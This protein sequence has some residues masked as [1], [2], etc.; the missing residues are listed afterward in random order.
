MGTWGMV[1][2][3]L[4]GINFVLTIMAII[5]CLTGKMELDKKI[6]WTIFIIVV[7]VIGMGVYWLLKKKFFQPANN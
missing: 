2:V 3:I 6:Y 4:A 1:V 7:P 5:N